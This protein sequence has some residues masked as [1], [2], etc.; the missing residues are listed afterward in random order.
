MTQKCPTISQEMHI[1][2]FGN[3]LLWRN[4]N[5]TP[6]GENRGKGLDDGG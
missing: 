2:K 1:S 4:K 3:R 6:K 5:E